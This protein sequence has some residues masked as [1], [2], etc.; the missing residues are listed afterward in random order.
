MQAPTGETLARMGWT[1]KHSAIRKALADGA[2]LV[3]RDGLNDTWIDDPV[4]WWSSH[5]D[6]VVTDDHTP[7]EPWPE[8]AYFVPSLWRSPSGKV[9]AMDEHC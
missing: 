1:G 7:R 2:A 4:A 3:V 6:Q 8:G 5:G 9:V